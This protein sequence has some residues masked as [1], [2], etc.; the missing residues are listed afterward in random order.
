MCTLTSG[1][2]SP[3]PSS[4][5]EAMMTTGLTAGMKALSAQARRGAEVVVPTNPFLVL[6][7]LALTGWAVACESSTSTDP[8]G[9]LDP[10]YHHNPNHPGGPGGDPG[11]PN[12]Y[13]VDLTLRNDAG[14]RVTGGPYLDEVDGVDAD[15]RDDGLLVI[16]IGTPSMLSF[17]FGDPVAG[18]LECATSCRRDFEQASAQNVAITVWVV[19]DDGEQLDGQLL[20]MAD[21]ARVKGTMK[22]G[23]F[24]PPNERK[25][26]RFNVRFQ[27]LTGGSDIDE[28]ILAESSFVDVVRNGNVWTIT[29]PDGP[30]AGIGDLAVLFSE[31]RTG[32]SVIVDEGTYH[33]PFQMTV[34]CGGC[35]S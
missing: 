12:E 32:K 14:D 1:A 2:G 9:S 27:D 23:F 7:A 19:D 22:L 26:P 11:D 24:H 13:S 4:T 34:D 25:S 3:Q 28:D 21:G 35:P 18:S 33:L 10:A 5:Q 29:A 17:D 30:A 20:A 16:Q 6:V 8:A 15:I 31:N